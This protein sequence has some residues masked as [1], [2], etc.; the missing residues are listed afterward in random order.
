MFGFKLVQI[1]R[2][3]NKIWKILDKKKER[4]KEKNANRN[5]NIVTQE[6]EMVNWLLVNVRKL[7]SLKLFSFRSEDKVGWRAPRCGEIWGRIQRLGRAGPDPRVLL[8][9]LPTGYLHWHQRISWGQVIRHR[10]QRKQC[11]I[12]WW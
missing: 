5:K 6:K 4:K 2:S 8:L 9:G 3:R 11:F 10:S 12:D 1:A 7:D